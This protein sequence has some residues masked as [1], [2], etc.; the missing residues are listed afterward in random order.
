MSKWSPAPVGLCSWNGG[1]A[2]GSCCEM[3]PSLPKLLG[4]PFWPCETR[5][6]AVSAPFHPQAVT[7]CL[8]ACLQRSDTGAKT[9]GFQASLEINISCCNWF[10]ALVLSLPAVCVNIYPES[11]IPVFAAE[12]ILQHYTKYSISAEGNC[13]IFQPRSG[14]EL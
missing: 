14:L 10:H 11:V 4:S 8:W 1:R 7:L 2:L 5:I 9:D 6:S 12:E 13:P 3:S